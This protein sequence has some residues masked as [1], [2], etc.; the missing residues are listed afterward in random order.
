LSLFLTLEGPD[1]SGKSTQS[2]WLA[3]Y[4]TALGHNVLLTREPGGAEISQQIRQVIMDMK[5]KSMFPATEFLLFSA[6]RAQLVREK[7]RPHLETGGIVIADRYSD[8]SLAYQGHG[9]GLPLDTIRA[10]TDFATDHL[11]PDLTLLLD[12]DAGR[13]LRRR[14]TPG[15]EWNRL[16]DYVLAFHQRVRQGYLALAAAE[17]GRWRIFNADQPAEDLQEEIRAVVMAALRT[18]D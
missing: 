16:D 14:Q 18:T 1:G 11:K 13:G 3:E 12:I 9:H 5:N 2:K 17:P 10:I 4:L 7:I 8:S 15:A 6:A